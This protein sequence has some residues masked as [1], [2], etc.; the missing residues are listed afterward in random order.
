VGAQVIVVKLLLTSGLP[1]T[2]LVSTRTALAA[3]TLTATI[4]LV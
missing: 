4:A 3:I 2:S 1:A